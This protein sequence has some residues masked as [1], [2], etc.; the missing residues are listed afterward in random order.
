MASLSDLAKPSVTSLFQSDI[1]QLY[2]QLA[3]RS[4]GIVRDPAAAAS[5]SPDID[6]DAPMMG[7]LDDLRRFGK[8]YFGRI[9]RLCHDLVC[10]DSAKDSEERQKV[11]SAFMLGKE[12]VGS[13]IAALLVA[14]LGLA[15]AVAAVVAVL[16]VKLFFRPAVESMC[17]VWT[18]NL[19]QKTT[20]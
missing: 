1:D 12:D 3:I 8:L 13:A 5:F 4:K 11:M 7:P 20:N 19:Q 16:I 10:G 14:H 15:P 9:N 18:E 2:E 6:Y 17:Q